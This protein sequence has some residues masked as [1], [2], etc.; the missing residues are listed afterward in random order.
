MMFDLN[1]ISIELKKTV[2]K[3]DQFKYAVSVLD[4]SRENKRLGHTDN[5]I[6]TGDSGVGKSHLVKAY[7]RQ[8]APYDENVRTIVPVVVV[9]LTGKTTQLGCIQAILEAMGDKFWNKGTSRECTSKLY[10][11]LRDNGVKMVIVDEAHNAL[12]A[13][14]MNPSVAM[15][16]KGINNNTN[17]SIVL[18]GIHRVLEY[19]LDPELNRRFQRVINLTFMGYRTTEQVKD[20]KLLITD[21]SNA[22]PVS[23]V[24]ELTTKCWVDRFFL[25]S[26]GSP[27]LVYTMLLEGIRYIEKGETELSLAHIQKAC[28]GSESL[29]SKAD[30]F[31][32]QDDTITKLLKEFHDTKGSAQPVGDIIRGMLKRF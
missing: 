6:I 20:F 13:K 9:S 25:A 7:H 32:Y 23:N 8:H 5:V 21:M 3:T 1:A 2:S 26:E 19:R 27:D 29:K 28:L 12:N 18:A 16:L 30:I 10:G 11:L 31:E 17:T 15:T 22:L 14:S 24:S 4:I